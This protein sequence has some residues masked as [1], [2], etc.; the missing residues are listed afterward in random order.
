[1][2]AVGIFL[3]ITFYIFQIVYFQNLLFYNGGG[4]KSLFNI[5]FLPQSLVG[6]RA[7]SMPGL[8]NSTHAHLPPLPWAAAP[9]ETPPTP[10]PEHQGFSTLQS[11]LTLN[12][13][14]SVLTS[15]F[16]WEIPPCSS[17]PSVNVFLPESRHRLSASKILL[18]F[19]KFFQTVLFHGS[20]MEYVSME[21]PWFI[22]SIF[23]LRIFRLFATLF[24]FK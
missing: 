8:T 24:V 14:C 11:L 1:M 7:P 2:G 13:V 12:S 10:A 17:K 22:S 4:V 20:S 16:A 9:P 15:T 19:S 23:G 21:A 5:S 3:F 18:A 6:S